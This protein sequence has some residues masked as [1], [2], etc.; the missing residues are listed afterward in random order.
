MNADEIGKWAGQIWAVLNDADAMGQKQLK[1][2]AKLK[3]DS[4]LFAAIG[5]LAREGKVEIQTNPEDPKELMFALVQD[6]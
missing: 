4:E 3:K 5:W 1:K 2:A 6:K